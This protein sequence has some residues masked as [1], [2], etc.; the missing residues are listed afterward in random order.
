MAG[1]LRT[2]RIFLS[3]PGDVAEERA[4]A[5]DLLLGLARGPFVRGRVHIDVVSWDDPHGG[6]TMD[7]RLTPQQ[8]VDRTL[9]T[10]AECDLTV[11]LL[12]G[13]M[14]TPLTERKPDGTPYLSGTE[15]EFENALL[16]NKPVF[17]YRRTERVLLNPDEPDFDEKL[18]QKRRVDAFF[19]RFKGEGGTILR[20]SATYASVDDL[21]DRLRHDVDG[22]LSALLP[23][24]AAEAPTPSLP[25][26][27]LRRIPP[28]EDV[29]LPPEPYPLLGPYTHPL[30]FAGRDAEITA[31]A[32]Q[33]GQP[34]L[35]LC[36][37]AASGAGKSS[38]L[39]AGLVPRLRSQG[40]AVSIDRAPGDPLLAQRLLRD[41]LEPSEAIEIP[42]DDPDLPATFARWVARAH[43]LSGKPLVF[44]L[45]QVDDVMRNASARDRALARIGPLLAATAQRLPGVQGFACTWVLCYRHEFHGEVR[46]WLGDVLVQ[47][48]ALEAR[49]LESL[50]F[51][52]SATQKSHDWVL[53][54]M[55]KPRPGDGGIDRSRHAFLRAILQ[56]LE[57]ID[58]ATGQRRYPYVIPPDG[59]ERLATAFALARDAQPDAPLVPELQ[60]VLGH[61]LQQARHRSDAAADGS[62]LVAVPDAEQLEIETR[63]ALAQ[64][65]E[66]AL[67]A[68]F[69]QGRETA[70]GQ[71]AR[72]RALIALRQ[73]ADAEGRRGQGLPEPDVIRM[74][75]PEGRQV[76][77]RLSAADTRLVV[78]SNG[79]CTLSHDLLAKVVTDIV[80]NEASRGNLVLDQ[81]LLDLHVK[82]AQKVALHQSDRHD[83]SALSLSRTQRELIEA[84]HGTL[85]F[86][87]TRKAWWAI[88]E[89]SRRR[90]TRRLAGWGVAA[91]VVVSLA[92]GI[93]VI[94]VQ[95]ASQDAVVSA[96]IT[97]I[98]RG[99]P[100]PTRLVSVGVSS[101]EL[102][103]AIIDRM[104]ADWVAS[105][106]AF[107][108]MSVA[109]E[110]V[111]LRTADAAL[112]QRARELANTVRSA[113]VAYHSQRTPEFKA[114]PPTA[115]DDGLNTWVQLT[116]GE[117][118]MGS[119]DGSTGQP[120]HPVRI[121][122]DFLIQQHE[123]T[124]EEYRRFDPTHKFPPLLE[125]HP[126]TDVSWYEAA[127]Y[128]A[129]L[130]ASLPTEAQWEYAARGTGPSKGRD[131]P[132][133]AGPPD[134]TR[135]V[136]FEISYRGGQTR[137]L[138]TEPVG[139]RPAGR[140]PDG[141]DDMA[142]NVAEWCRDWLG[143]YPKVGEEA[144]PDP[145]GPTRGVTGR[146]ARELSR[147][148]RV[149]RG[150]S[151]NLSEIALRAAGRYGRDP[152]Y[153]GGDVGF[154]LVSSHLR[155]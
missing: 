54:V 155:P 93:G 112:R 3:S 35:V 148:G 61:L 108:A 89:E 34:P 44:V 135:A 81:A 115:G 91:A 71:S 92:A 153:R 145:L 28:A 118:V 103:L 90:R 21:L 38:L 84:N 102:L 122:R 53:P 114:P 70:P 74:I 125:D 136:Y 30:T 18:T 147:D 39:L 14:G 13:R 68:A 25:S 40:R 50:P 134:G 72:T 57:Q 110:D 124:N 16:A 94:Q 119:L 151:F 149:M 150:G 4:Q 75:G 95:Q 106:E 141:L 36:V 109:L 33:V 37:H 78:T 66:R 77:D 19:D 104:H 80:A 132:W 69:P 129:W 29:P 87:D 46:A 5:R 31:L 55:G 56:P 64:H 152:E 88:A 76:L 96:E 130:G 107:G 97:S 133:P 42:D 105:A 65:V 117:F 67:D 17:V 113:F 52:L 79:H 2:V 140:T 98:G 12:W 62:I 82:I 20:G 43:A 11:V 126:V 73:L 137:P 49:G 22:H 59:A 86:N 139:S 27:A 121:S 7:A 9:P 120:P 146:A 6:A 138:H 32:D 128:A 8:A 47:A 1:S 26:V 58:T 123:V 45:D 131:Y 83:T 63:H 100:N 116:A 15:W 99:S 127:G 48:R 85:L 51:D 10:P 144:V 101:Q 143:D 111:W 24:S 142:G 60:V 41:I 154:R 23:Q